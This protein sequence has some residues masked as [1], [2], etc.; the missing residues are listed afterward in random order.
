M[1]AVGEFSKERARLHAKSPTP[2]KATQCQLVL[3]LAKAGLGPGS[4]SLPWSTAGA[5]A[6]PAEVIIGLLLVINAWTLSIVV[7]VGEWHKTFDLGLSKLLGS[8]G[9]ERNSRSTPFCGPRCVC[10]W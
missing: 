7:E 6:I 2:G 9:F 10:A 1:E 3:H 5:S 8:N 4:V